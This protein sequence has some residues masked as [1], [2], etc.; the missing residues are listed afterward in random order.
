M[1]TE[2]QEGTGMSSRRHESSR[3]IMHTSSYIRRSIEKRSIEN[4]LLSHMVE[5]YWS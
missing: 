4:T 3:A 5:K 1:N 2:P